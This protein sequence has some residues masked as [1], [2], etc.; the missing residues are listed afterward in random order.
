M[1]FRML[2]YWIKTLDAKQVYILFVQIGTIS[3]LFF[4][5]RIVKSLFENL[6]TAFK[7]FIIILL[8]F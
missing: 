1:F 5:F 2:V 3:A 6:N 8:Y 7:N 4:I